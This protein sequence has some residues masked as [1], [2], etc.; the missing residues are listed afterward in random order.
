MVAFAI[1]NKFVPELMEWIAGKTGVA[2][3]QSNAGPS[4]PV[5]VRDPHLLRAGRTGGMHGPFDG[6][7]LPVSPQIWA[8]KHMPALGPR[9]GT[10]VARPRR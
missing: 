1:G 5:A 9:L 2:L 10:L 8:N 3:R 4:G 6:E 7:S